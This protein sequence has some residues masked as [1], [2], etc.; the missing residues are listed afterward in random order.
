MLKDGFAVVFTV[1]ISI[2][3]ILS[4]Y[5]YDLFGSA[6]PAAQNDGPFGKFPNAI[7]ISSY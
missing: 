6:S 4:I 1:Q 7:I 3:L 2:P 5:L